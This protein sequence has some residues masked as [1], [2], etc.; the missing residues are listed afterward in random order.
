MPPDIYPKEL[1][2]ND[3][4]RLPVIEFKSEEK[5]F[6]GFTKDDLSENNE[7]IPESIRFPDFSCNWS[8]FSKPIHV[9]FREN[10]SLDDGCYS[11]TVETA[12]YEEMA[13]VVHDPID[14][15]EYPNY[16][17]VEVRRLKEGENINIEPPKGRQWKS[18]KTRLS[19][20][21]RYRQNIKNNLL[22]EIEIGSKH[23]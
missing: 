5:L 15:P 9:R 18:G 11:F 7:I 3:R 1:Y 17:H 13:N 4:P 12:R 20:K 8:R 16:S 19:A 6:H 2:I 23:E 14:D 10:G 22:V 21:M